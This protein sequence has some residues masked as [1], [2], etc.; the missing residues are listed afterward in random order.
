M[1]TSNKSNANP[2][3]IVVIVESPSKCKKIE[4][5]LNKH[6]SSSGIQ[7]NCIASYGH[8][9]EMNGL[10]SININDNFKPMFIESK[11][12][13]DQISK[14]KKAIKEADEVILASDDD[15]E[16]EAIA[17]HIC[18]VFNLSVENTK[19][20]LFHEIKCV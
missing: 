8:I 18:Q 6:N 12:K 10:E 15:R 17:W 3:S 7:Y 11:S 19:R 20:I 13:K 14:I 16:G 1:S 2:T 5:F 9:R 4:Q